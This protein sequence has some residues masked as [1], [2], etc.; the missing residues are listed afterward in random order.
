MQT[1]SLSTQQLL[2]TLETQQLLDAEQVSY[3]QDY[4][5]N[6]YKP[7]ISLYIKSLMNVGAFLSAFFLMLF[8]FSILGMF[9]LIGENAPSLLIWGIMLMGGAFLLH[10]KNQIIEDSFNSL[11]NRQ[12]SLIF[13]ITG[14]LLFCLG[15]ILLFDRSH[16]FSFMHIG[17]IL[18]FTILLLTVLTYSFYSVFIERFLAVFAF[19]CVATSSF[20]YEN[21][22][23]VS[24]FFSVQLAVFLFLLAYKNNS[25]TLPIIYALVCSLSW[26]IFMMILNGSPLTPS[27]NGLIKIHLFHISLI[28][29]GLSLGLI[30]SILYVA[31]ISKKLELELIIIASVGAAALGF[32]SGTGILLA[33]MFLILGRAKYD[34]FLYLMGGFFLGIF[35][36]FYY[37]NLSFT[38]MYKAA[39][40]VG[41][42]L[43]L[44]A[45]SWYV[46]THYIQEVTE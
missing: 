38:L 45:G 10:F 18:S 36:F 16:H 17:W 19:L 44:L 26:I 6:S 1:N 30:V 2:D 35:L 31:S 20:Y 39:I 23:L 29:I 41:S 32:I 7:Q 33:L 3:I 22:L 37:Y 40:L 28:N 9:R 24:L 11:F 27:L 25:N 8:V 13:M 15:I 5:L 43:L 4:L 21:P 46:K 42:G 14:K 34:Q 12:L